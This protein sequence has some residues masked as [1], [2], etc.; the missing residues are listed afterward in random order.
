MKEIIDEWD[1]IKIKNFCYAKD[2]VKTLE[3]QAIDWEKVFPMS[4]SD[5]ALLSKIYNYQS[6]TK[7]KQPDLKNMQKT[8]TDTSPEKV[9]R[10]W[11]SILKDAPYH[12]PWGDCKLK[13]RLNIPSLLLEWPKPF[14]LPHSGE[15]WSSSHAH[16]LPVG[17]QKCAVALEDS[18]FLT[19]WNMLLP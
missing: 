4:I 9:Y 16:P 1:F 14:T 7:R 10:W 2:T 6:L 18:Q 11:I 3:W 13:Q 15:T 17:M 19:K 5:K 8:W 12:S